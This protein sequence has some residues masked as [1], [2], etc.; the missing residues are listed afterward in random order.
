MKKWWVYLLVVIGVLAVVYFVFVGPHMHKFVGKPHKEPGNFR[1]EGMVSGFYPDTDE[2]PVLEFFWGPPELDMS[3]IIRTT[4]YGVW[5]GWFETEEGFL[6]EPANEMQF[7]VAGE[8]MPTRAVAPGILITLDRD[9]ETEGGRM[10]VLYGRN[11]SIT[12]HHIVDIPEDLEQGSK[13]EAGQTVGYT[14]MWINDNYGEPVNESWWEI[15]MSYKKSD[16]VYRTLPPFEYFSEDSQQILQQI[17]DSAWS[18]E[19]TSWTVREGCSWIKYVG[20]EWWSSASTLGDFTHQEE[21]EDDFLKSKN[22]NWK[23]GDNYGRVLGPTDGC[24]RDWLV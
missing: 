20:D 3:K 12:Y 10:T 9:T 6:Y 1:N 5:E 7:Y 23:V 18:K 24:G 15:S 21:T 13:I 11:Y 8:K 17:L 22:L 14:E 16:G 2:A 4:P 19:E